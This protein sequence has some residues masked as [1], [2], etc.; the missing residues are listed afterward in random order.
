VQQN[1]TAHKSWSS[2]KGLSKLHF[3]QY[4]SIKYCGK[5]LMTNETDSI[6]CAFV[7][8]VMNCDNEFNIICSSYYI[9]IY[10]V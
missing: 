3:L 8:Y 10:F 1:A 4:V 2:G 6:R 9:Y 7:V 5:P